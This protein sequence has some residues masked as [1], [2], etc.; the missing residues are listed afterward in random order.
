MS[1]SPS[2]PRRDCTKYACRPSR[3]SEKPVPA[4]TS[5]PSA[6]RTRRSTCRR[7]GNRPL[8]S[9]LLLDG[10][11]ATA[12]ARLGQQVEL[13][14]VGMHVVRQHA[15]RPEQPVPVVGVGVVRVLREQP[16]H[17]VDLCAVLVDVRGEQRAVDVAEHRRARLQHRLAGGQ[18]E[19]RGDGVPQP[20]LAV[21]ARGQRDRVGVGLFGRGQQVRAQQPVADD[22]PGWL[23]RSPTV[24]AR[25]K[26]WS[27]AAG[28]CAPNT[29]AVVVP[30]RSRPSTN[31]AATVRA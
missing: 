26:S 16:A 15:A 1:G 10:Q 3:S 24:A 30:A 9:A 7:S 14:V 2:G 4:P 19:P 17:G 23:T 11:C 31:S 20:V 12:V 5:V 25:S 29:S 28:K 6:T 27:T 21:P 8:P 22:E 18:R 13:G